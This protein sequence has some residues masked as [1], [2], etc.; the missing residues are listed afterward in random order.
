M[1]RHQLDN[2]I[3]LTPAKASGVSCWL[4]GSRHSAENVV[5]S[6]SRDLFGADPEA[7]T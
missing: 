4:A 5:K 2:Q 3:Y 1:T 7:E 6:L